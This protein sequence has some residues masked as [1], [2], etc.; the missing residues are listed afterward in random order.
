ML[1]QNKWL[2]LALIPSYGSSWSSI[3]WS[4]KTDFRKHL[5]K[6]KKES[7]SRACTM[8]M[9]TNNGPLLVNS[10]AAIY[11]YT[12][13]N[14]KL[15]T[16]VRVTKHH[17][18]FCM[19]DSETFSAILLVIFSHKDHR[20]LCLLFTKAWYSLKSSARLFSCVSHFKKS[21][22]RLLPS[23]ASVRI[24][25][26]VSELSSWSSST[27]CM[28]ISHTS[29]TLEFPSCAYCLYASVTFIWRNSLYDTKPD[30]C[31]HH[32]VRE[33]DLIENSM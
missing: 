9:G 8:K 21:N 33:E 25:M 10:L 16:G 19:V 11:L 12:N 24:L 14:N 7:S 22:W 2:W 13:I 6:L 5:H 31:R 3:H 20:F 17:F 26:E 4:E 18:Y 23:I 15:F 27:Y 28:C 30:P 29:T 32:G 1:I